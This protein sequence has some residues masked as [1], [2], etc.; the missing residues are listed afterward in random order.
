M[1]RLFGRDAR[2]SESSLKMY[3]MLLDEASRD[4][5]PATA[6]PIAPPIAAA[7]KNIRLRDARTKM[8]RR[9]VRR[10]EY[11]RIP[12]KPYFTTHVNTPSFG[13]VPTV[14]AIAYP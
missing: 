5:G 9:S 6:A 2:V 7:T 11:S 8:N 3:D 13:S 14:L 1:T 4:A 10:I 12:Q